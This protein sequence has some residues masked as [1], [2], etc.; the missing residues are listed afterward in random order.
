MSKE[1]K[2]ESYTI[3]DSARA[4]EVE[5]VIGRSLTAASPYATWKT[6]A[7]TDFRSYQHGH[8]FNT[9]QEARMDYYER[10][11]DAWENYTPIKNKT[12][13]HESQPKRGK[14]R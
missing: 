8:Y 5:V 9:E 13:E 3:F 1:R 6:Y 7:H 10:L 14:T 2:C 12:Q 4:G 11:R